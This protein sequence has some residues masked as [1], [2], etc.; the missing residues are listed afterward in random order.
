MSMR[1]EPAKKRN[2]SS[3]NSKAKEGEEPEEMH[4]GDQFAISNK[5]KKG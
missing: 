2:V 3:A 5:K 4:A 1:D